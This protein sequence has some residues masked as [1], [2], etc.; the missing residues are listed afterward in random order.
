MPALRGVLDY[1]SVSVSVSKYKLRLIA[2]IK[3]YTWK[4][5]EVALALL[6]VVIK[7]VALMT[8]MKYPSIGDIK[9]YGVMGV[10]WKTPI[11]N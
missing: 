1:C 2:T 5:D 4:T 11:L 10:Y 9:D 6:Q 8:S 3:R 7:H